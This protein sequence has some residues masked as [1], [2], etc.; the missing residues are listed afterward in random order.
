MITSVYSGDSTF[1]SSTSLSVDETVSQASTTTALTSS[2]NP[3][4]TGQN[5]TFTALVAPVAPGGGTPTGSVTFFNGTTQLLVVPLSGGSAAYSTSALT[6]GSY[7]I[8][9][10]YTGDTNFLGSS[11]ASLTQNV[12]TDGSDTTIASSANPSVF[13]QSVTFTAQVTPAISGSGTPL[14]SVSFFDGITE[15]GTVPLSG[16]VAIFPTSDLS[17]GSHLITAKYSGDS[18]FGASTSSDLQQTV[19]QANTQTVVTPSPAA[20]ILGGSVTFTAVVTPVSPASG[21]PTGTVTFLDGMSELASEPLSGGSASFSTSTLTL[22]SH[23]ITAFYAGDGN[24]FLTSVSSSIDE[25]VGGTAVALASSGNPSTFG[26][27]ETFTAT[28]SA[29]ATGSSVPTGSVTFMDGSTSLGTVSLNASGVATSPTENLSGGTHAI[30]AVYSGGNRFAGST[31]SALNQLVKPASTSTDLAP[32]T[33]LGSFSPSNVFDATVTSAG[34]TPTGSVTFRDGSEFVATEDVNSSGV[35][36]LP[37]GILSVGTHNLVA[38]YTSNSGN[39]A[40]STSNELTVDVTQTATTT[41]L[42]SSTSTPLV[43]QPET[44]TATVAAFGPGL[45]L[46]TG[47]VVFH[48]GSTVIGTV[49]LTAG[50]ASLTVAYPAVGPAHVIEATYG[51]STFFTASNSTDQTVSVAQATPATTLVATPRIVRSK[52]RGAIL[53]VIVQAEFTGG[54]VPTCSVTFEIGRRKL[55]TVALVNGS[56]SVAVS[57]SKARGKN[58]VV[59]YLGD[60]KLQSREPRMR[61]ATSARSSSKSSRGNSRHSLHS[62]TQSPRAPQPAQ[63]FGS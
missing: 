3:S 54:P 55:R 1:A 22:G 7:S 47:T 20:I 37:A 30:T 48:D 39:F 44:F 53:Q 27:N 36:E 31:S 14:G 42:T 26:Q 50:T 10:V 25:E 51:G 40:P 43:G 52:I 59:D 29:D 17:R 18:G 56:A 13:G 6:L 62:E 34:G 2:A 11:S 8:S 35:A 5:V 49:P 12:N 23:S 16:G 32:F 15:L 28:V 4:S 45:P 38:T 63:T 21:V 19:N 41:I 9:A 24:D 57:A 33:T 61:R 58:F 60:A 46:P